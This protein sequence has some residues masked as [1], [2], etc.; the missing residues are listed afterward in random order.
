MNVLLAGPTGCGKSSLPTQLAAVLGRP[1]VRFNLDGETRVSHLRGQHRPSADEGVLTLRF[2]PG[3]LLEAMEQG[4]WVIFDELDAAS[5]SVLFVLQPALE[6]GARSLHVPET[7]VMHRADPEFRVFATSNTI[8]FRARMRGRH[9]G[10][11]VMNTALVDRFGMVVAV[12]Y[13]TKEEEAARIALHVPGL[14]AYKL[15]EGKNEVLAGKLMIEAIARAA[16]HL[17]RDDRFKTDFSTR[18]CIQW[19][20]LIEQYPI[21]NHLAQKQPPFDVL[22]AAHLSVLR[23]LES[24]TDARVAIEV[25]SRWLGFAPAEVKDPAAESQT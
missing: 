14:A 11:N 25:I 19:A 6:E 1:L 17:R 12:D 8:G 15:G 9:A 16:E 18:R 7:G 4:W 2:S 3:N 13:P 21:A 10:A 22:R 23:K 20:R 5:P 24:P